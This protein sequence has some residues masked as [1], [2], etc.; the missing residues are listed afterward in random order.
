MAFIKIDFSPSKA[1]ALKAFDLT[2][3]EVDAAFRQALTRKVWSY[4]RETKRYGG[5]I[6]KNRTVKEIAGS[7]R[8]IV[9]S[10]TLAASQ[11]RDKEGDGYRWTWGTKYAAAVHQGYVKGGTIVP[12]RPWT[13]AVLQGDVGNY[14]G[15]SFNFADRYA[16]NL[17]RLQGKGQ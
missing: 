1:Q 6:D 5:S 12:A 13:R 17:N 15:R 16:K 7:P 2:A 8:N 9:D 4:P 14:N 10:G 11:R 3:Q